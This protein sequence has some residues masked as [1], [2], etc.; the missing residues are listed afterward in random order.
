MY[1]ILIAMESKRL[2]YLGMFV[3]GLVG[4]YIPSLWGA[5]GFSFSSI[6]GNA[7]GACLGIWVMFKISRY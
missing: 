7:I 1:A 3:G 2:I 5:G 6:I 4:G